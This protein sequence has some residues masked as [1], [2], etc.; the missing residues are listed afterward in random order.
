M[1]KGLPAPPQGGENPSLVQG[2]APGMALE[3][4]CSGK[5]YK[6]RDGTSGRTQGGPPSPDIAPHGPTRPSHNS[7][8]ATVCCLDEWPFL[9]VAWPVP[10]S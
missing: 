3:G 8:S 6:A 2:R 5:G 4:V 10:F 7:V 1:H 9:D